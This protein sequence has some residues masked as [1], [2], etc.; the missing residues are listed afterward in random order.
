MLSQSTALPVVVTDTIRIDPPSQ[1]VDSS[2][3]NSSPI[4]SE[5]VM[6]FP[7]TT[8]DG[9]T[10]QI[11]SPPGRTG[12]TAIEIA[13]MDT[14]W[15]SLVG[16]P[17][18]EIWPLIGS[19]VQYQDSVI[20]ISFEDGMYKFS[21]SNGDYRTE[22]Y[23]EQMQN[24]CRRIRDVRGD[25]FS[26]LD[27]VSD[28]ERIAYRL[29]TDDYNVENNRVYDIV[30]TN[31][32]L[33]E[34]YIYTLQY[35]YCREIEIQG[36]KYSY[37]GTIADYV[38]TD[39]SLC[40][41]TVEPELFFEIGFD[42]ILIRNILLGDQELNGPVLPLAPPYQGRTINTRTISECIV[43]NNGHLYTLRTG[44]NSNGIRGAEI[45]DTDLN[46]NSAILYQL[47]STVG[48]TKFSGN[49]RIF[50]ADWFEIPTPDKDGLYQWTGK[51]YYALISL[52]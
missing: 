45:L 40:F 41:Y 21:A 51:D 24:A 34:Q 16:T 35:Y 20:M 22:S 8:L 27:F 31:S 46:T 13:T 15:V 44:L 50:I 9:P 42:G 38:L 6:Y 23:N 1:L 17:S 32:Y 52:W 30:V 12:I 10:D 14:L 36:N 33:I 26:S 11:N 28:G 2:M 47:D 25:W 18:G 19:L 7:T 3:S 49:G 5:E 37:E 4:V 43:V 48:W 39:S 29:Y